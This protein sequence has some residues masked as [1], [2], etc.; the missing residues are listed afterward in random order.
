MVDWIVMALKW[1]WGWFSGLVV[2]AGEA[3]WSGVIPSLPI[4]EGSPWAGFERVLTIGNQYVPIVEGLALV[5]AYWAFLGVFIAA[6][7]ALKL[8]PTIG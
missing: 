8:I 7:M 6:K 3:L 1:V 4:S 5:A 2:H